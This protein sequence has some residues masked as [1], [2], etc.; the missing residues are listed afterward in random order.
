MDRYA[1]DATRRTRFLSERVNSRVG[2]LRTEILNYAKPLCIPCRR[3]RALGPRC[4]RGVFGSWV[5]WPLQIVYNARQTGESA[6]GRFAVGQ[7]LITTPS[8][9]TGRTLC[10]SGKISGD[11]GRAGE[12]CG[13]EARC[14]P[15]GVEVHPREVITCLRAERHAARLH[16]KCAMR[17]A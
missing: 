7:R 14:R 16:L 17:A 11:A 13:R 12:R 9:A 2:G 5:S 6:A 15:N 1:V 10:R 3:P 4:Y 8:A